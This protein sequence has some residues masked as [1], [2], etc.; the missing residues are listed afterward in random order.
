MHHQTVAN[1][2]QARES[3]FYAPIGQAKGGETMILD[4]DGY[5][6]SWNAGL[7]NLVA[8]SAEEVIGQHFSCLFPVEELEQ[9]KPTQSLSIAAA[10]DRFVEEGWRIRKNGSRFWASVTLTALRDSKGQLR[11]FAKVIQDLTDHNSELALQE[12]YHLLRS[13]IESTPDLVL[14]KDL[15]GRHVMA[16]SA[17][18]SFFEK[19]IEDIIGQDD[20]ALFPPEIA[21]S[22]MEKDQQVMNSGVATTSEEAIFKNE[23]SLTYL[24]TKSPWRDA[25]G[26]V[27]GLICL[28][29]DISDRKRAEQALMDQLGL[30]AFRVD[31][32]ASLSRSDDLQ[33]MLSEC[34]DAM[35]DHLD[36]AFAR[37]WLFN[38]E[39]NMLELQASS[40]LYTHLDGPHAR[41]P[42]GR[43][44]IGL[45]AAERLPHLTNTVLEDP[46]VGDKAWAKRE[47]MVAFAGY[48]LLVQ[49]QLLGVM[50]MFTRQ[51]LNP[52]TL[53]ALA[54]V[55][56]EIALGIQRKQTET[57][58]RQ[59]E[60]QL[61]EK[62]QQLELTL[63]ELKET[64][65]QII[66]SE[67]MSSL[68]QLV[69][70][71]AHEI[72][73]PVNF[74]Y[75]NLNHANEYTQDLLGLLEIYQQH[76]PQ[77][78]AE[79]TAEAE[80]IDL[81]FLITDL[82]KLLSSMKVGAD[83][84]R[85]IVVSLRNFS[86]MDESEMKEVD[87]HEGIDS[88]LMILQHRLK[89]GHE[90]PAIKLIKEYG[91]IPWV[92]CYVGQL[93]QVFMNILSNAID[94]IE[95]RDQQ[96]SFQEIGEHPS[97]ICIRTEKSTLGRVKISIA[98]N[99]PGLS[100]AVLQR[101]FEPFFTTKA[102][103]KGTGLGM[104]ISHQ[105]V[106][107]KHG[108]SLRCVSEVG[109]GAEFVIEIPIRQEGK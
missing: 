3:G 103:G 42:V 64:Q 24:S 26:R 92:E 47:G 107:E 106:T 31:V 71:V 108:G 85:Q 104:S 29:R 73:N 22:L 33:S 5:I 23:Q 68:G 55:S 37:I 109:Q 21:Y 52:S 95:E 97:Q 30:A 34:T 20:T 51:P 62:A 58:L 15:H 10:H 48:P 6:C 53:D 90:H 27:I 94:A 79:V 32:D 96:R 60:T 76:Y 69:A 11:G 78:A 54:F 36:A 50:A 74:I 93:N 1:S 80:A 86:R 70:G 91:D 67:K 14:V 75:G 44:K 105:I 59:S 77:P 35:V 100:Q 45:I 19:S 7:Q 101:L 16:N 25:H 40:G 8:Y 46:R 65:T 17:A 4:P 66:Q 98:D 99:G 87:L 61:R 2:Y 12:S 28:A 49:D 88:T 72:N 89:A 63:W 18:I 56:Q 81:D 43:F 102:V 82:P 57:A 84:I 41:V 9:G 83:R 13:V 38:A 39:A